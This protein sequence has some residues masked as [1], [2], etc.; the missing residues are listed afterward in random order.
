[1]VSRFHDPL[2]NED[3]DVHLRLLSQ[4]RDTTANI[5]RLYVPSRSGRLVRLDNL[6]RLEDATAPSRIERLDR[7]RQVSVRG[8]VAQGYGLQD[9]LDVLKQV[10]ADFHMPPG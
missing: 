8:S 6:V 4:Y 2:V 1:Q 7:M 3:Y 9:R 5:E 10:A